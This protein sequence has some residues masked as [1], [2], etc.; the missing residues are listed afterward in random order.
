M[1]ARPSG[2]TSVVRI[3]MMGADA[4]TRTLCEAGIL[5]SWL[6]VHSGARAPL[7]FSSSSEPMR[8]GLGAHSTSPL[9]TCSSYCQKVRTW[10]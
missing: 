3:E 1:I 6:G 8:V 7:T 2:F 4:V 9:L 10:V 5:Y